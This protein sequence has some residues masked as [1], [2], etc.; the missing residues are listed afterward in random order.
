MSTATTQETVHTA[1]HSNVLYRLLLAFWICAIAFAAIQAWNSR[2]EMAPDGI[3]YLDNAD[4]YL[5]GDWHNAANTQWSPMYPWLLAIALA[6][7]KPTSYWQFP[8]LHLVNF[9]IFLGA[10]A[11]FQFFLS[12][13]FRGIRGSY[14]HWLLAAIAC[15]S[16]L[17]AMVDFT[18]VVNPTPDLTMAV[19]V[20]LT[21]AFL[22]RISVDEPKIL[23]FVLL[24]LTLGLGYIAKAPFFV[25]SFVIFAI[26]IVLHRRAGAWGYT[27]ATVAAFALIAGPYI[28]FL[29]Y[30]KGRLTYGDSGKYNV[31]WMV[32]RVPYYHWQGG[33]DGSGAPLHPT[34]KL[35]D[36]PP[37]Y[38][39]ATPI[40]GAYPPWYDPIYWNQGVK[41]RYRPL[42]FLQA[43]VRNSRIYFYLFHRRQTPLICGFAILCLL[44]TDWRFRGISRTYLALLAF[45]LFPFLMYCLVHTDGRFLGAFF[46]LLW[47]ALF[48]AVIEAQSQSL[49]KPVMAVVG[50]VAALMVVEAAIVLA[51]TKQIEGPQ[52]NLEA[53]YSAHPQW[54]IADGLARMG[55][56]PG[57]RAAIVGTDLPYFWARL[58]QVRIVAE[59]R[60]QTGDFDRAERDKVSA[61]WERARAILAATPAQFVISPAIPG[62]VDE[63]GW[64]R[65]GDTEAF[66][67]KLG[68]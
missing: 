28:A 25:F 56:K 2:F 37:V 65:V 38:E 59:V 24:G 19:F 52:Q 44:L 4:A 57:A 17:Y 43:A 51:P 5:R 18:N 8:V 35:N 49:M 46:V 62:I 7:L 6:A 55:I 64:M 54:D 14:P 27:I 36:D 58:A 16:F 41:V 31:A 63:P 47:T 68:R 48:G 3:Q 12:T 60:P 34:H 21:A 11:A 15:A 61:E 20:F 13:L 39:Y 9:V 29:S 10:L 50:T 22:I 32:N 23:T 67:Y 1:S 26:I 30:N 66:I 42:D 45:A 40:I 53:S 33:N